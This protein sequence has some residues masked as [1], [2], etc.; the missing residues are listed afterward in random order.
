MLANNSKYY[1][2]KLG[3]SQEL[4]SCLEDLSYSSPVL[5]FTRPFKQSN[6]KNCISKD[7]ARLRILASIAGIILRIVSNHTK[8]PQGSW[9]LGDNTNSPC[10]DPGNNFAL[11][12]QG[13]IIH[14]AQHDLICF[15]PLK[16]QSKSSEGRLLVSV[17]DCRIYKNKIFF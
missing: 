6:N 11:C 10:D 15:Q 14:D 3:Q 16:D 2:A 12:P 9:Q 8:L 7:D 4:A 1:S 5:I 17:F 13:I